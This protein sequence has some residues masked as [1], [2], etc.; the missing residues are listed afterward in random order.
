MESFCLV[1][2]KRSE[3]AEHLLREKLRL[4]RPVFYFLIRFCCL[5]RELTLSFFSVTAEKKKNTIEYQNEGLRGIHC[6]PGDLGLVP[7]EGHLL[8]LYP[9]LSCWV[10][11]PVCHL[12]TGHSP[13]PVLHPSTQQP[14]SGLDPG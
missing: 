8:P 10:Q 4:A 14:E 7:G 9:Q 11:H 5:K 12:S 6:V 13:T 1:W 3:A 2:D